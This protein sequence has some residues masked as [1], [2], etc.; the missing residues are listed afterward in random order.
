MRATKFE[1]SLRE[2]NIWLII[3]AVIVLVI[4]GFVGGEDYRVERSIEC[5]GKGLDYNPQRDRCTLP[6]GN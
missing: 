6:K 5:A 2:D 4:Y 3:L 1:Q